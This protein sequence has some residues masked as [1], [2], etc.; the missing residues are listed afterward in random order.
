MSKEILNADSHVYLYA[1]GWYKRSKNSFDDLRK[2]YAVRNGC[3]EKYIS[4]KDILEMVAELT[5]QYIKDEHK[6]G[7]FITDIF[8]NPYCRYKG[9]TSM[10]KVLNNLL[11]ILSIVQIM[12]TYKILIALDKPDSTILPLT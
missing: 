3:D 7:N 4:N 11:G 10:R 6:F 2:I 9:I 1:K 12:T 5:F 8:K